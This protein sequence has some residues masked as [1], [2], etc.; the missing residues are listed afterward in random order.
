MRFSLFHTE[1]QNPSRQSPSGLVDWHHRQQTWGRGNGGCRLLACSMAWMLLCCWLQDGAQMKTFWGCWCCW[2]VLGGG[3][4]RCRCCCCWGWYWCCW[5]TAVGGKALMMVCFTGF[6]LL[7]CNWGV[8]GIGVEQQKNPVT[9]PVMR[10]SIR[11]SVWVREVV[12]D[13]YHKESDKSTRPKVK[14]C[15][16]R[17]VNVGFP[18]GVEHF[19]GGPA[20]TCIAGM[21][22]LR[23]CCNRQHYYPEKRHSVVKFACNEPSSS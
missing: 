18:Q 15:Y 1:E 14:R 7:G 16:S 21:M 13:T 9:R 8:G 3:G 4:G 20:C 5:A 17:T 2:W 23:G 22:A 6:C 12:M 10:F 11:E 19:L